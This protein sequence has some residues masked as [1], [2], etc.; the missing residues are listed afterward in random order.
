MIPD[1]RHTLQ[2]AAGKTWAPF[3]F[4]FALHMAA[5]AGP[6]GALAG[7]ALTALAVATHALLFGAARTLAAFPLPALRGAMLVGVVAAAASAWAPAPL[8]AMAA[9]GGLFLASAGALSVAALAVLR[10]SD[11]GSP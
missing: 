10:R 4:L 1:A 2:R 3:A 9:N 11:G 6:I 5:S 8:A 7:G